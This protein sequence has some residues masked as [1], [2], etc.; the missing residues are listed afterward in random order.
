MRNFLLII[1]IGLTPIACTDL[2]NNYNF[3]EINKEFEIHVGEIVVIPEVGLEIK[4]NLV[5]EDSRCPIGAVCVWEGN[6]AVNLKFKN[7]EGDTSVTQLNTNL[8]PK[9]ITFSNLTIQLKELSPCPVENEQIN[10]SAYIAKLLV[11]NI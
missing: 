6:A 7:S 10:P 2:T 9:Q 5:T 1:L 11:V 8:E 4:F 3:A